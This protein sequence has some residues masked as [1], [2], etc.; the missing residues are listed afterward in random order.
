M[1][2]ERPPSSWKFQLATF[3]GDDVDP[4]GGLP[5]LA[6]DSR[7]PANGGSWRAFL[8]NRL[9]FGK[10]IAAGLDVLG[11]TVMRL[12]TIVWPTRRDSIA[13]DTWI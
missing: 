12:L 9:G 11:T 10:A 3:I 7:G 13:T 5:A 2:T 1:S 8:L 4:T 6:V